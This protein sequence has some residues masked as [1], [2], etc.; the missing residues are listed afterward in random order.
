MNI[1]SPGSSDVGASRRSRKPFAITAL[2]LVVAAFGYLM[3]GG[4][5]DNLVYFL[6]PGELVAKGD[7]AIDR[8][9]RLGGQV[10]AGSVQW[11]ADALDLRFRVTDGTREVLVHS[12]GAPPQMFRA[13]IGV[14]VEGKYGRSGVFE[15]HSLM[16][17]HSNEYRAPTEGD[18]H[19]ERLDKTLIRS[20][21]A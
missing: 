20:S 9:V 10:V 11:D 15:S 12:S 4:V 21:G 7:K 14:V 16:V 2:L 1:S 18:E 6:T 3:Y 5:E 8:P 13:G 19:P 17:K